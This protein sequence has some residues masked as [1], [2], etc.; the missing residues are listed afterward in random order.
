[1]QGQGKQSRKQM[2]LSNVAYTQLR[3]AI[4]EGELAPG[5]RLF[6][7]EL[8][9]Q[10][11]MGRTPIREALLRLAAEGLIQSLPG[12]KFSVKSHTLEDI[13]EEYHL[14][15]ALEGVAVRLACERGIAEIKLAELDHW[16]DLMAE[17]EARVDSEAAGRADLEFHRTLIAMARS[18]RLEEMIR[19]SHIQMFGWSRR[20]HDQRAV[21]PMQRVAASHRQLVKHLRSRSIDRALA[22]LEDWKKT[23]LREISQEAVRARTL[24]PLRR[25]DV[26][27]EIVAPVPSSPFTRPAVQHKPRR[28]SRPS[29]D[30]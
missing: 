9:R 7:L 27:G 12:A 18:P 21:R 17:A 29:R 4:L 26:T 30:T 10:L 28:P 14:R 5:T 20:I 11:K 6:E 13:E 19:N 3:H 16:C 24:N 2:P 25:V 15:A 8:C 23:V 22:V 1:M